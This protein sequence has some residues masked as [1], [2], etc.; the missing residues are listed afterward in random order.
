MRYQVEHKTAYH[1]S[2]PASVA[3]NLLHLRVPT[4]HRQSVEDFA[5]TV[6]PKPRSVVSRT[7]Y[8]GNQVHYF[9]LSE[10]HSGMTITA[11]SRVVVKTPAPITTSPAWEDLA[12]HAKDRDFPLEVR[13]YLFPSRHIR[14]LPILSEYGKAAF[15]RARP[16]VEAAMELTTRIYTEYKYDSNA[17][18]I[19]TPLEEV[20]RQRHGVCQ[21]FAHVGIGALRALGL[22]ARY[23][24]GYLRTEPPPGKPR[25]VGADA[26]HAWFSVFCG[27]D[28]GWIDFDPT[29]NVMVGT[30]HITLAHGRDFEDVSPIQG[31]V[32]GGGTRTM[33]VGVD[34]MPLGAKTNGAPSGP[35]AT[36]QQQ[37]RSQNK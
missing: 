27:T 37:Q 29:N 32:M 18:N 15:T 30:D 8:F 33:Q 22:P 21:D 16:I 9:A 4:T 12:A 36:Q 11:T 20:V 23:V 7:D 5:L 2:E 14:M 34:V 26:S 28:L 6:E 35:A 31:V 3:H 13:Q 25:L 19:F 17:T 1:Y 24:S 10:P